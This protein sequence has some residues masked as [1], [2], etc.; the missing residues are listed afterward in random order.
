M[1]NQWTALVI[2]M[3]TTNAPQKSR[4]RHS[5]RRAKKRRKEGIFRTEPLEVTAAAPSPP[6]LPP[7]F[8]Q[9]LQTVLRQLEQEGEEKKGGREELQQ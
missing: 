1:A 8:R 6:L 5:E 3:V 9:H 7:S 2:T 4:S